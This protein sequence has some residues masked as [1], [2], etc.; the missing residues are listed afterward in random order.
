LID[1]GEVNIFEFVR[2]V[3]DRIVHEKQLGCKGEPIVP[4]RGYCD[5]QL[6]IWSSHAHDRAR[7]MAEGEAEGMKF[8][9]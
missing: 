8:T 3:L 9:E 6:G 4:S 5:L 7:L 1:E 2:I